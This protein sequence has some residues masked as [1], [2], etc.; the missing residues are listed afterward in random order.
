MKKLLLIPSIAVLM[1]ACGGSEL[2]QLQKENAQL[3]VQAAQ[4]DS[5]L[6]YFLI[7]FSDIT[8]NLSNIKLTE[9]SIIQK[10]TG[11]TNFTDEEKEGIIKNVQRIN[12]LMQQNREI[13]DT[14]KMNVMV[15]DV[16]MGSFDVIVDNLTHQI[17]SKNSEVNQLKG[18][19]ASS[20]FAAESLDYHLDQLMMVSDK[21]A[22]IIQK[23]EKELHTAWYIHGTFKKLKEQGIITKDKGFAGIGRTE[24][25]KKDFNKENFTK[26]DIRKNTEITLE[27]KKIKLVTV[28]SPESYKIEETETSK[29]LTITDPIEFWHASKYLVVITE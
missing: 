8:Q 11:K 10:I 26:I 25:L 7:A 9:D 22:E 17:E 13:I 19:L 16:S 20:D 4:K 5:A 29:K 18:Q 28:H 23:Q 2:G 6:A 1:M 24:L 12:I 15:V 14:L 27:S 3:K 21:Q